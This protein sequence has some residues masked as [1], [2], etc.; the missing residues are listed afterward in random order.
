MS[1]TDFLT[2]GL[3]VVTAFYVILTYLILK[4]NRSAVEMMRAQN[5]AV[6]RPLISVRTFTLPSDGTLYLEIANKGRSAATDLVLKMDRDFNVFGHKDPSRNLRTLDIFNRRIG[7]FAQGDSIQLPLKIGPT[8]GDGDIDNDLMPPTFRITASYSFGGRE[9]VE[10]TEVDLRVRD[11][12]LLAVDHV[13]AEI[14]KIRGI[15]ER[16]R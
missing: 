4:T 5:E 7:S 13:L 6:H 1:S 15:L 11:G 14:T 9:F 8:L 3:V 2:A 12:T 10:E 16:K